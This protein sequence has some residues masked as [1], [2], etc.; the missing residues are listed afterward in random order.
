MSVSF[1]ELLYFIQSHSK[2]SYLQRSGSSFLRG[3]QSEEKCDFSLKCTHLNSNEKIEWGQ[4]ADIH[5]VTKTTLPLSYRILDIEE[6]LKW[7]ES[8]LFH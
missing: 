8:G 5:K 3:T 6:D 1:A 2:L 7:D 4:H